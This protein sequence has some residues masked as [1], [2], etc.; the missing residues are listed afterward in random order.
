MSSRCCSV[1][2]RIR[3]VDDAKV[4]IKSVVSEVRKVII[5]KDKDLEIVVSTLFAGGHVLI[6]GYP[7]TGKTLMAKSLARCIGGSFKRIQGNPDILPTD[8][9]G[10]HIYT[11][12]GETKFVKGPLFANVVLIDEISRINPR[13]QSAILEAM[14]EGQVTVDG[15]TYVLPKPFL[16]I[17]TQVPVRIGVGVY[18]LTE[19]L[20]DRFSSSIF[21]DYC[22]PQHEF[23]IVARS[24]ELAA[25]RVS[26]IVTPQQVLEIMEII[27]REVFI[28]PRIT[29]YIVDLV[30]FM[31]R[32]ESVSYGPSHRASIDLARLS[33]VYAAYKGRDY[34]IPDDVKTL[35]PYVIAHRIRLT[36]EAEAEGLTSRDIV[37]EALRKVPVPKE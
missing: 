16:V 36:S 33:R 18:P 31:R 28:E 11:L 10:F 4:L 25:E 29:K 23:E 3:D 26:Q 8:I 24:D 22:D 9:T 37:E 12:H 34:V 21:S 32:H 20:V 15:I 6:E 19:T 27:K 17:A 30:T 1:V 14:Q 2:E 7:G 5:G 35:A 13:S